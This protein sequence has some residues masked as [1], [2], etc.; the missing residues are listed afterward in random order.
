MTTTLN[1]A[2]K[3]N[4]EHRVADLGLAEWGRKDV[5]EATRTSHR[6]ERGI[7]RLHEV[8]VRSEPRTHFVRPGLYY[9]RPPGSQRVS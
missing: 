5:P 9:S 6:V 8:C 1:A 3:T 2:G 7:K 4:L